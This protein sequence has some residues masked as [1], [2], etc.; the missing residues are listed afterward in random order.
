M[1]RGM[2]LPA[3]FQGTGKDLVAFARNVE[4]HGFD[5][6][7]VSE[8]S[9]R[10]VMSTVGWLLAST[11]SLRLGTAIASVYARDAST[12]AMATHTLAE[13][14]GGRFTL[15]LGVSIKWL[16]ELRGQKWETPLDKATGYLDAMGRMVV[17]SP[18]PA[19]PAKV[20]FAAH[21]PKL[22]QTVRDRVDGIITI[23]V[24]PAHT[25]EIRSLLRPDQELM[26]IKTIIPDTNPVTAR[27]LA[28]EALAVYLEAKQYW[29]LWPKYGFDETT[30]HIP[31][32]SDRL[33]DMLAAWGDTETIERSIQEYEDAGATEVVLRLPVDSAKV[34]WSTIAPFAKRH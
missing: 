18:A 15:G 31:G 14:S 5:S 9:G 3:E 24:P 19:E 8:V 23:N 6:M 7:W 11:T 28:R 20:M 30:D 25:A 10:E 29:N 27:A 34:D 2:L 22:V 16:V 13:L 33:I 17:K 26:V 4:A 32:G 21:G 1:R 12:A